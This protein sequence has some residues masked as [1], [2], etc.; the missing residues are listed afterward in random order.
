[1]F[2]MSE[3]PL[4][5]VPM[6]P[7]NHSKRFPCRFMV[8]FT[9]RP[10]SCIKDCFSFSFNF[11]VLFFWKHLKTSESWLSIRAVHMKLPVS[12]HSM[13]VGFF[14]DIF[15]S[16]INLL[17]NKLAQNLSKGISTLGLFCTDLAS[18]SGV[19]CQDLRP[20][21]SQYGPRVWLIR[22]VY[23][24]LPAIIQNKNKWP[25][26]ICTSWSEYQ[27]PSRCH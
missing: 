14:L 7:C 4:S 2:S 27:N 10:N 5:M 8:Y 21:F 26:N 22:Y 13:I 16:V 19:Y 6:I 15:S 9:K 11:F 1:M 24:Y 17:L 23:T 18:T 3:H 25:W 20:T 12:F